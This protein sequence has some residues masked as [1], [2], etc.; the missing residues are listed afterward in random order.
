CPGCLRGDKKTPYYRKRWRLALSIVCPDCECYLYD[1]CSRCGSPVCF[2]RN[3][4]GIKSHETFK[5]WA[6]CSN[7]K[8]DLR[9]SELKQAPSDIVNMQKHLYEIIEKGFNNRIIF[10][11]LYFDVLHQ[12]A[13]L[14]VTSRPRLQS[15]KK[16][17]FKHHDMEYF[18][19]HSMK[20]I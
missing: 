17:I 5:H 3:S 1:C 6:I 16:D 14:L 13:K 11:I 2:F 9:E 15:L 20:P 7:C 18:T 12:V 4:I 8:R 10:P 19:V